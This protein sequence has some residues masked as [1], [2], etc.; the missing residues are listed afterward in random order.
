MD[1]T[2]TKIFTPLKPE[3]Q[4]GYEAFGLTA[5]ELLTNE[6]IKVIFVDP[7]GEPFKPKPDMLKQPTYKF[8]ADDQNKDQE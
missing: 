2:N 5:P 6:H 8:V 7:A 3:A 4:K 1:T